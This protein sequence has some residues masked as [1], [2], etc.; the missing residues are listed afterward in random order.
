M[1]PALRLLATKDQRLKT[2]GFTLIEMLVVIAIISILIGIG[3]NTFTIAQKKARDVRRKADIRAIQTALE[4]YAT[5]HSGQYPGASADCGG[6]ASHRINDSLSA[7]VDGGYIIK[8]PEDPFYPNNIDCISRDNRVGSQDD[9]YGYDYVLNPAKD[10]Y[11]LIARLENG[12]D[13]DIDAAGNPKCS[14]VVSGAC[15]GDRLYIV[16]GP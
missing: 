6:G 13:K 3:I 16:V 12:Q 11:A 15:I 1:L 10:K 2:K 14:S 9:I 8:I 7:L 4:A 5:D